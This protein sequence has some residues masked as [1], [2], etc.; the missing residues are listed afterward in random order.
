MISKL[1]KLVPLAALA[2]VLGVWLDPAFAAG[3]SVPGQLGLQ[4]P[5]TE[6]MREIHSLYDWVNLIIIAIAVFVL[7]LLAYVVFRFR[8][9]ANPTPSRTTH[10]TL[11]EVAWTVIPIFIL[12]AI[13][14]P[15]FKLLMLQYTY[16]KPDV[17]I[18]AIANAWFWEHE[19]PADKD[20]EKS[21]VITSNMLT[22][23]EAAEKRKAG[24]EAPRMLAVDNDILV[25]VNKVVHVL[26]TSNDVLHNWTIPSFG[27]KMDAVPGRVTTTWFRAE[28]EGM[29]WGQCSELCGLKHSA[30]PI[31]VRVVNDAV[32]GEWLA[33]MR[34]GDKKKA[35]E[36][37]DKVAFEHAGIKQ[38]AGSPT[39]PASN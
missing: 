38:I 4:A 3:Q 29:Y 15:S 10:N 17:T 14:I 23:E 20:G 24:L 12:V 21:F 16:P 26:I 2:V 32:Y 22:D 25:P 9:S 33:A 11:L 27:S 31:G 28:K 34:A 7:V 6:V 13:S 19:Y 35:K 18:K 30:M 39:A 5:V 36:I 37:S 1:M 8:E